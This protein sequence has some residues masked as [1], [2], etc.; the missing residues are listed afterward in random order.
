MFDIFL[1]TCVVTMKL[2]DSYIRR[3]QLYFRVLYRHPT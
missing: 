3:L 1:N 2:F